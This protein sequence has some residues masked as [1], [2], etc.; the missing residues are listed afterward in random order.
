MCF[1]VVT[2]APAGPLRAAAPELRAVPRN[3]GMTTVI[4]AGGALVPGILTWRDEIARLACP[5]AW[6]VPRGRSFAAVFII[7]K[8]L[9]YSG[10]Q[11]ATRLPGFTLE[12]SPEID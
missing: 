11:E 3:F 6:L 5:A 7:L 9:E 10:A 4:C 12:L 2:V 8:C 1:V